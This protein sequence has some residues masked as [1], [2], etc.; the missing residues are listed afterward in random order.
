MTQINLKDLKKQRQ[1]VI[2]SMPHWDEV[3]RGTVIK[4]YLPCGKKR[5]RCKEDK[6]YIHGPYYYLSASEKNKK[7]AMQYLP[8][9]IRDKV[10]NAVRCY[11]V[12]WENLCKISKINLKLMLEQHQHSYKKK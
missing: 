6:K 2:K 7:T 11:D 9:Q 1:S 5:C 8:P 3:I 12:V 10:V 4:Y